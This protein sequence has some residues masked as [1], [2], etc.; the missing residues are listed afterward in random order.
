MTNFI[1]IRED[2][3]LTVANI[4]V[5]IPE[6]DNNLDAALFENRCKGKDPLVLAAFIG[7]DAA[8]YM[9]SYDRYQDGSFYCWMTGVDPRFRRKGILTAMMEYLFH[10]ASHHHYD[11]IRIK[12]R[13]NRREM[14]TFLVR[15][16]FCFTG[17]DARPDPAENRIIIEKTINR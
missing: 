13:N 6:F 10:W 1:T 14:L 12:T 4:H 5:T 11:K 15:E 17:I 16:G 3:F 2:S 7:D 8:G 9:I